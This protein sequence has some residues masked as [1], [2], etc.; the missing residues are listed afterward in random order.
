M[1]NLN[2]LIASGGRRTYLVR[3]FQEALVRNGVSGRVVLADMDPF[4]P[5]RAIA[6]EFVRAPAV[7]DANYRTWLART[8]RDHSI[9]L[10]VSVNDFELSCW[11][12]LP[13]EDSDFD[14]LVRLAANVHRV[15]EDK[16]MTAALLEDND[17]LSPVTLL[18]KDAMKL[19]ARELAWLFST[20]DIVV[21]GRYG[22]GSRG[23]Q[24]ATV[25]ELRW[26]VAKARN[27]VT[28]RDGAT[29]ED[30]EIA[31]ELI[32]VQP[33]IHGQEFG[34]DV[35]SDFDGGH[36]A[37]LPR[38]K[39]AM[40]F[41]ET[42][43]AETQDTTQFALLGE[44]VSRALDHRGLIDLDLM[45]DEQ[46]NQWVIDVNPRF[47][48]GYPFSHAAGA[49]VPAAYVAWALG[50][51]HEAEWVESVAGIVASKYIEVMPVPTAVTATA[52]PRIPVLTKRAL[53]SEEK[54]A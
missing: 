53:T 46:G 9:T 52:V 2:I 8:L 20:E 33:R 38:K 27:D 23:L 36:V 47:G 54:T 16:L 43:R 39:L 48:G 28:D 51:G 40:R 22:S 15:V 18:A 6:D 7:R 4:A 1:T 45:R 11:A 25:E 5:A 17:V 31:D 13:R 30:P 50:R 37:T 34:V 42:D 26:A 35:I 49:H 32:V 21:K 14:P 3:W 41:G 19:S 29:P 24:C 12:Q 10:A 44:Q